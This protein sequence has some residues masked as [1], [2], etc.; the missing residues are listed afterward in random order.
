MR[1]LLMLAMIVVMGAYAAKEDELQGDYQAQRN[2]AYGHATGDQRIKV[3][4]QA[5]CSWY[6]LVLRSDSPRLHT[7]DVGNVQVYCARLDAE[8]RLEAERKAN[9]LCRQI[10]AGK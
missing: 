6:L 10:Y 1:I 7:G 8:T 3:D 9:A 2:L 5:A 4:R